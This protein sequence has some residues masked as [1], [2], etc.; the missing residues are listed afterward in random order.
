MKYP[1]RENAIRDGYATRNAPAPIRL[2]I[3]ALLRPADVTLGTGNKTRLL[4]RRRRQ[5]RGR[6]LAARLLS[7][8]LAFR[9]LAIEEIRKKTQPRRCFAFNLKSPGRDGPRMK[10]ATAIARPGNDKESETE[11]PLPKTAG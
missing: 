4:V 5:H 8:G 2:C 11:T 9:F 3:A 1:F 10:R 6:K 7:S